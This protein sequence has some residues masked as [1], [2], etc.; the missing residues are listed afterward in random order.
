M[1]SDFIQKELPQAPQ[2]KKIF[3]IV[4]DSTP[5]EF[6]GERVREIVDSAVSQGYKLLREVDRWLLAKYKSSLKP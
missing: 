1:D 3:P 6:D 2:L 4:A 5:L